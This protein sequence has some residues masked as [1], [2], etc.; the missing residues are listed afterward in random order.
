MKILQRILSFLLISL[1]LTSCSNKTKDTMVQIT[2]SEPETFKSNENSWSSFQYQIETDGHVEQIVKELCS[3]KYLGR[4]VGTNEN[5][6]TQQYIKS[7]FEDLKIAPFDDD[8][9]ISNTTGIIPIED[10]T[11]NVAGIIKGLNS[12]KAVYIT[13]HLD[14]INSKN[15]IPLEGA[16]DNAS[17]IA[18]LLETAHKLKELTDK[19]PLKMDIVFV[20]FNAEELGLIGSRNF[21]DKYYSNYAESY[22]INIDCVAKKDCN[23][24]SMGND[25]KNSDKLYAA[26]KDTFDKEGVI[27]DNSLYGT[28]NGKH[29]GTSDHI[30][31]RQYGSPSLVLGDSSIIG[32]VHTPEDNLDNVDYSDL[33]KLSDVLSKFIVS[34][35]SITFY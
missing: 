15:N 26:M 25:D 34:N 35:D 31:I 17:G 11:N 18:V 30:V 13:A 22:N 7:Y 29:Y 28:K 20:A 24:L 27:Y 6:L 1:L 14:H 16:I 5:L 19:T 21:F 33:E 9:Y 23:T 10:N 4:V 3:H 12:D 32:F 2:P 8:Y